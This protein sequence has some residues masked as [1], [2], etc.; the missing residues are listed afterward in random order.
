MKRLLVISLI[1]LIAL[2]GQLSSAEYESQC[3]NDAG[4][5]GGV[6]KNCCCQRGDGNCLNYNPGTPN[7]CLPDK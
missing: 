5:S 1:L 6:D 2:V 3:R 4:Y 7:P